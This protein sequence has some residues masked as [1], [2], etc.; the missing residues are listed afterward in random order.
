MYWNIPPFMLPQEINKMYVRIKP[1]VESYNEM[2]VFIKLVVEPYL[3]YTQFG[4]RCVYWTLQSE[5]DIQMIFDWTSCSQHFWTLDCLEFF[6]F[7]F[8]SNFLLIVA[9]FVDM[10]TVLYSLAFPH[11][12]VYMK[13]VVYGIYILELIQSI[14]SIYS[15]FQKFVTSFGHDEVSDRIEMEWLGIPILT[16]IGELSWI[17]HG[18][19]PL[20]F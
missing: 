18:L 5:N 15:G 3:P 10:K 14:L 1:V 13:C 11:D 17:W 8:V 4:S 9:N 2:Y 7:K 20:T 19:W 6:Q 12:R 16:A